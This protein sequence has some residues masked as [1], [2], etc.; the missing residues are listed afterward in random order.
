MPQASPS[1]E[2]TKSSKASKAAKAIL[3]AKSTIAAARANHSKHSNSEAAEDGVPPDSS[4][5]KTSSNASIASNMAKSLPDSP[6]VTASPATNTSSLLTSAPV[7]PV[8]APPINADILTMKEGTSE[9]PK[10][11]KQAPGLSSAAQVAVAK[12]A[13][14]SESSAALPSSSVVAPYKIDQDSVA[15]QN[16]VQAK[17]IASS[18]GFKTPSVESSSD[19][20]KPHRN[21]VSSPSTNVTALR[22][23]STK[24][25]KDAEIFLSEVV[26]ALASTAPEP[27]K[28]PETAALAAPPSV[29]AVMAEKSPVEPNKASETLAKAEAAPVPI[30]DSST[31]STAVAIPSSAKD[32]PTAVSVAQVFTPPELT[33]LQHNT[34]VSRPT[35]PLRESIRSLVPHV[36]PSPLRPLDRHNGL[37][38]H[39]THIVIFGWMDA[40]VRLV[41]KYAQP[42][43]VLFPDATVLIQ[44]SDG[45]SYLARENVRREQLQRILSEISTPPKKSDEE[46]VKTVETKEIGESTVTLIDHS[47]ALSSSSS[48]SSSNSTQ[49]AEVGGFV[50]HSFSDGGAG[51]LALFL[52]EMARRPGPSPRVHSLIMDSSPGK[53]NP[54]TGS[55]AFTM[56]LA[57]RPRLRTIVQFFV[58]IGLYLMKIWTRLTGK[59]ARGE[60]MR[61]RLNSLRSWSWVTASYTPKFQATENKAADFPP[62]MYMYTKADQ[63]IPWQFVEEHAQNLAGIRDVK[64]GLVE[65]QKKDD[66]EKLLLGVTEAKTRRQ[67]L[68]EGYKV[69]LRRWD[70]PPHCS[71]GRSDFEGYWATVMD[72][73]LNV[74]SRQ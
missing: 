37:T 54:K 14:S 28:Q 23:E 27:D 5:R 6:S 53:S 32:I 51:N 49:E 59:P 39:P 18:Q 19:A 55:I 44:L 31:A 68:K 58:Y 9:A 42:Y 17:N 40:P 71:I 45:K 63:L 30:V 50:I 22:S 34:F 13:P 74:L 69:E 60:L 8:P 20:L 38:R 12:P 35:D 26:E 15:A 64:V 48:T 29:I 3:H 7:N 25:T 16:M 47:E 56:H 10:A 57:N 21:V 73:Y 46:M 41:A 61:K 70:T 36:F 33:E 1:A 4:I 11:A 24:D 62:R 67:G 66:R 2:S 52:D 65:V 72:F 43:T